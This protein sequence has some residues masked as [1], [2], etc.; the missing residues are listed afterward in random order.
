MIATFKDILA[1]K[2][3]YELTLEIYKL[4]AYFPRSE[5]F[6]L[7]SQLRRA[8]VSLISNIAEGYKKRTPKDRVYFYRVAEGSLEE[9]KC[10]NILALDL[11]YFSQEQYSKL[12]SLEN[13]TGKILSGWIKAQSLT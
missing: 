12:A 13:E 6:G 9:I 8:G 7:K 1:W 4:T 11:N 5:E 2:K 10:Q 3:G